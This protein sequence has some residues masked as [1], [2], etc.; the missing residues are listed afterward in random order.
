MA[1]N[2]CSVASLAVPSEDEMIPSDAGVLFRSLCDDNGKTWAQRL[3]GGF[4]WNC[5]TPWQESVGMEGGLELDGIREKRVKSKITIHVWNAPTVPTG[6]SWAPG[7]GT[8][9]PNPP[10]ERNLHFIDLGL[11]FEVGFYCAYIEESIFLAFVQFHLIFFSF[12]SFIQR[13]RCPGHMGV[14]LSPTPRTVEPRENVN[15][16]GGWFLSVII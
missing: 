1:K 9:L 14:P 13:R 8:N 16:S 12:Q 6:S 7:T 15:S 10:E 11:P 3:T 2:V 4:E 5:T